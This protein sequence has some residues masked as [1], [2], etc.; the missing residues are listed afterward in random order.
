MYALWIEGNDDGKIAMVE[1]GKVDKSGTAASVWY[2]NDC[3]TPG[4]LLELLMFIFILPLLELLFQ[5]GGGDWDK[6]VSILFSLDFF[7]SF[8]NVRFSLINK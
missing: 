7:K 3:C 5:E 6:K 2:V 4:A 1:L 8:T